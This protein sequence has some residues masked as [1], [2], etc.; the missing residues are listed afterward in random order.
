[1]NDL[2]TGIPVSSPKEDLFEGF[3]DLSGMKG[4]A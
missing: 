1:M 4:K 2:N 3:E